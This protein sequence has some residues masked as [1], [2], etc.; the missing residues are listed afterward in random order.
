M[1]PTPAYE[2]GVHVTPPPRLSSPITAGYR[3][4]HIMLRIS[5]PEASLKFYND[6]L[7][8]HTV[9]IFNTG[10]WTIYYLGP[11]DVTM[12]NMGTAAGLIELYHVP[13]AT[14]PIRHGNENGGEGFGHL[15]FT[16]PDV[17][18]ALARAQ[19]LGYRIIKPLG[20]AEVGQM[21]VP[22][23]V[24]SEDIAEGYKYVFRQLA[25]IVDP[26]VS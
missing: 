11:R 20:Q 24:K 6:F 18:Q 9:F 1:A 22:D 3:L 7:G 4:N 14:N 15:G 13:R 19:E 5:D 25:F 26:D 17:A 23:F 16:V 2:P 10:G 21:G 8:M 12:E